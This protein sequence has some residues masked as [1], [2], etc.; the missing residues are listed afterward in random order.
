MEALR[1]KLNISVTI[2]MKKKYKTTVLAFGKKNSIKST[3]I[4][5]LKLNHSLTILSQ[6]FSIKY[7][8]FSQKNI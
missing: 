3:N 6:P 4:K 1:I 8:F 5:Y 2:C 7:F